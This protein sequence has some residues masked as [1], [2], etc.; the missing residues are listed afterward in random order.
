MYLFFRCWR[1]LLLWGKAYYQNVKNNHRCWPLWICKW[2]QVPGWHQN[3][4]KSMSSVCH[5][6]G[7]QYDTPPK[8]IQTQLDS[9]TFRSL[10]FCGWGYPQRALHK[11]KYI[12]V[13]IMSDVHLYNY[14]YIYIYICVCVYTYMICKIRICR[15]GE[16]G[17]HIYIYIYA[18]LWWLHRAYL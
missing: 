5:Y 17:S 7:S 9:D 15:G 10:C 11:H 2:L 18:D 14:I 16:K 13:Y 1:L 4:V 3:Y 12:C 6:F 8:P